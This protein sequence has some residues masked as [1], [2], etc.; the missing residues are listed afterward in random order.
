MVV[1][2]SVESSRHKTLTFPTRNPA[3]RAS[4][5]ID[6]SSDN[7]LNSSAVAEAVYASSLL[8][9]SGATLNTNGRNVYC[10][11]LSNAGTIIGAT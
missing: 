11:T 1:R 3:W 7:A 6:D 9:E 8:I 4:A 10:R 5:R 2:S